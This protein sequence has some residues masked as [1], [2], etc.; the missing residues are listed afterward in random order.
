MRSKNSE[1]RLSPST[2]ATVGMANDGAL[3]FAHSAY[4][5][6]L[7]TNKLTRF[8]VGVGTEPEAASKTEAAAFIPSRSRE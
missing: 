2:I 1:M 7:K 5:T 6:D 3:R 8:S 4:N